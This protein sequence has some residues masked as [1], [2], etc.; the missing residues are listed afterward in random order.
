MKI[1][2][3]LLLVMSEWDRLF[4]KAYYGGITEDEFMKVALHEMGKACKRT[5]VRFER[6][7]KTKAMKAK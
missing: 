1:G 6:R 4:Q 5:Y 2:P 7:L 3:L